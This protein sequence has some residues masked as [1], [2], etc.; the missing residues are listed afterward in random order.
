MHFLHGIRPTRGGQL[1]LLILQKLYFEVYETPSAGNRVGIRKEKKDL[2][3]G[4]GGV[5]VLCS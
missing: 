4:G 1:G 2:R 3:L 5:G